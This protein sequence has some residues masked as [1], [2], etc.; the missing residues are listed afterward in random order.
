[1]KPFQAADSRQ[2]NERAGINEID[3]GPRPAEGHGGFSRPAIEIVEVLAKAPCITLRDL[4]AE[5][6]HMANEV[7]Q[8]PAGQARSAT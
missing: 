5:P 6:E 1:M 3:P 7:A 8:H 4:D 2:R